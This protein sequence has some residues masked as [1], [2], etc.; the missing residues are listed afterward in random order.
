MAP[1]G[2]SFPFV[3]SKCHPRQHCDP[4]PQIRAKP[5]PGVG[6]LCH[7]NTNCLSSLCICIFLPDLEGLHF[8]IQASIVQLKD[9]MAACLA[10]H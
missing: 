5:V 9:H 7:R 10:L 2:L 1:E 8:H 3:F 4:G 6:D